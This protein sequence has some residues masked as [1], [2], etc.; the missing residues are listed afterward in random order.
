MKAFVSAKEEVW[1]YFDGTYFLRFIL[2]LLGLYYFNFCY[3]GL[4]DAT[5][6]V[7]SPF[8]GH[9]VNYVHWLRGFLLH[10]SDG[11]AHLLGLH[12]S[13]EGLTKLN[14]ANR[15]SLIL[16]TPCIGINM[17]IFWTAFVNA[18]AGP[19]RTNLWWTLGGLVCICLINCAR[20]VLLACSIEYRWNANRFINHHDLFKLVAYALILVL[21][22]LYNQHDT[23]Q[24]VKP[25]HHFFKSPYQE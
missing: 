16:G 2:L 8:L 7:Y 13:V 23:K 15:P 1:T 24:H 3:R 11:A 17:L 4:T 18:H 19:W 20:I 9:Y 14:V 21:I 12:T 10:T 6:I 25:R 22:F 5:G